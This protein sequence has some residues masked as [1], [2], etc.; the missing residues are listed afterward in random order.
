LPALTARL[1]TAKGA[2]E[3]AIIDH[4]IAELSGAAGEKLRLAQLREE[5]SFGETAAGLLELHALTKEDVLPRL[6]DLHGDQSRPARLAL[7][8]L[9][10]ARAVPHL[11][12]GIARNHQG[13]AAELQKRSAEAG[14]AGAPPD[15]QEIRE[16]GGSSRLCGMEDLAGTLSWSDLD[17]LVLGR[18]GGPEARK[19]LLSAAEFPEHAPLARAVVLGLDGRVEELARMLDA[20]DRATREAAALVLDERRDQRA[21]RELLAAAAR[22]RGDGHL[23]WRGRA[24]A[25]RKDVGPVLQ[26]LLKSQA[27]R[28]RVLAESLSIRIADPRKAKECDEAVL[29]AAN[30]VSCMHFLSI[31][32]IEGAGR[33]L[34]AKR[35]PAEGGKPDPKEKAGAGEAVDIP[36]GGRGWLLD[37]DRRSRLDESHVPLLEATCLFGRGL[38]LRGV[39]AFALAELRRPRSMPVLA[40]SFDMGSLGG[41]NPAALALTAFGKEGA[42]LAAK[43]PAPRPAEP[44]TGLQMT[45]HRAGVQVLAENKDIRGVEE[46]LKGLAALE[47]DRKLEGWNYRAEIYLSAAGKFHDGR[48]VEPLMRILDTAEEPEKWCHAQVMALLSAYDDP[49]IPPMLLRRL[50]TLPLRERYGEF[51]SSSSLHCPAAVGLTRC[52]GG[53]AAD[54]LMEEYGRS[55]EDRLRAGILMALAELSYPSSPAYPG[56][57][58]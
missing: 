53:R 24:L 52:L 13:L 29:A 55:K 46:I 6:L 54:Y 18:I 25:S 22:R 35:E 15:F 4:L 21:T 49:R 47:K 30:S 51:D 8:T 17:I 23:E 11:L 48:L 36:L 39:A 57:S 9:K 45:H 2:R 31:D 44:D 14:G 1:E 20:K 19:A 56:K 10:D 58:E 32:M 27:L 5:L 7:G 16:Q 40:A 28:E 42:E 12:D 34:A 50:S 43:V 37:A 26:E 3:R 38:I 33:S 41:S